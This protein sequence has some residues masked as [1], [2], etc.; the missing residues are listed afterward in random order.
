MLTIEGNIVTQQ[1]TFRGRI[2]IDETGVINKIGEPKGDADF[3]FKDELI[4]PGFI[5]LHVHAREC[6]D[7]RDD[8]KEDFISAGEAA[9]NGGVVTFCDMPN[10]SVPPIDDMS[11]QAKMALIKKPVVEIILYAGIKEGTRP[12]AF[13][14]PYKVFMGPSIGDLFFSS[15]NSLEKVLE[16]YRGQSV[17]FHCED[18]KILEHHKEMP[19]HEARRP[20]EA[21][22]SAVEFAI[23]LME[24]YDISGKVC[25]CS[26]VEGMEKI[27]KAKASGIKIS[28]E[29]TPHHLY[30]DETM[31][32]ENRTAFQVNPPIRQSRENR[33]ALI[34]LL[35]RGEIDFLATDHAPHLPEEKERG[36]SGLAH[37][38]TYGPFVSWLMVEHGFPAGDVLRV[39]ASKPADFISEFTNSKYGEIKEGYTGSITVLDM[40]KPYTVAKEKLKTKSQNSPFMGVTF[41]GS[42]VLT[43]IKGK[44]LKDE[45]E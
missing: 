44:I 30:F 21:E 12:L 43:I 31:L 29:V 11:Y 20:K 33:L 17:S 26:T 1:K 24:K 27:I 16:N 6:V 7:H 42:V 8:Y 18:P 25:H 40:N 45:V 23:H 22:L 32:G 14:V 34:E 2:E 15:R 35:R 4:F 5:D 13:K 39:T 9:I 38:D 41:P 37:L 36:I 28:A 3:V 19:T 10:N